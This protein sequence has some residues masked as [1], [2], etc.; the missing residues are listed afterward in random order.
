MRKIRVALLGFGGIARVH[1]NAY[2]QL[3]R[4]GY[5][6]ELVAV[7]EKNTETVRQ[8]ITINLGNDTEPLPESVKV[9]S[10]VEDLL[11][12]E[13]YDLADIC[14]PTF[15]HKSMSVNQL[16]AGK[17]V[18]CEKP[19]ALNAEDCAEM[20]AAARGAGLR[21]MIGQCL[22]FDKAYI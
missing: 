17:H 10:C 7:C 2:Q 11:E 1:N 3:K 8:A 21:L 18:L 14:L 5:P 15:L 4:E 16:L 13:E 6:V 20:V 19:M 12:N 9:Y 22:R